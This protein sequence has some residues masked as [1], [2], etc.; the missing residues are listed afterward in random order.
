VQLAEFEAGIGADSGEVLCGA[1]DGFAWSRVLCA[2]VVVCVCGDWPAGCGM[3]EPRQL[4]LFKG[5][6]QRGARLP[7]GLEFHLHVSVADVLRRWIMPGWR[8]THIASGEYRTPATAARL[9]RM[10][11]MAGWPDL[12]LLPPVPSHG[13]VFLELKRRGGR[14]SPEQRDFAGWAHDNGYAYAVVDN[15]RSAIAILAEWGAVRTGID[16]Q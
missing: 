7:P 10:G 6:R 16:A 12:I 5:R 14:L 8:W 1:G 15:L 11:V 2:V 13:A 9:A 3:S 4:E